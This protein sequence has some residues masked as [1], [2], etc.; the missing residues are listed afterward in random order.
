MQAKLNACLAQLK[1]TSE[2][3]EEINSRLADDRQ[4]PYLKT[5]DAVRGIG[6]A[7]A[8]IYVQQSLA[9]KPVSKLSYTKAMRHI[10]LIMGLGIVGGIGSVQRARMLEPGP[11]KKL[12]MDLHKGSGVLM[13]AGIFLRMLLRLRSPIPE[14]FPGPKPFKMLETL[15][16]RAFYALMLVLPASGLAYSWYTGV[17]LPLLGISKSELEDEDAE[18]AQTSIEVHKKLGQFLEYAWLPYHFITLAIH[19]AKGRSVVKRITPF[20]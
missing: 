20:P 16:H 10:H 13:L 15:S 14:R 5:S 2:Q 3:M 9:S 6:V 18:R 7:L 8:V 17:E 4:S 1:E 11:Q 19:S 12:Y